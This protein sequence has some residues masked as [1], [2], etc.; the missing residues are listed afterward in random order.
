VQW[1]LAPVIDP[2]LR[3]PDELEDVFLICRSGLSSRK[4]SEQ[5]SK[6]GTSALDK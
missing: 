5:R 4:M 2:I 6:R 3:G 1:I